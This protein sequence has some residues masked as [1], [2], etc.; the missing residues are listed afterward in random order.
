MVIT[1]IELK[2]RRTFYLNFIINLFE[3]FTGMQ[4]TTGQSEHK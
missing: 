3:S 4:R 2:V 1:D